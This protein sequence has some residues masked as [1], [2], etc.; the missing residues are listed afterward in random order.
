VPEAGVDHAAA[1]R[2]AIVFAAAAGAG[3]IA[4]VSPSIAVAL[5]TGSALAVLFLAFVRRPTRIFLGVL[6]VLLTGYAFLGKGLAHVGFPPLYIG[7]LLLP[8]AVVALIASGR[9]IRVGFVEG[10]IL[11]FIA[12]GFVRMLPGFSIYGLDSLRDSVVWG[13]AVY[14][15]AVAW[16]VGA[17][18]FGTLTRWYARLIPVFLAWIPLA[19]V[20][21]YRFG[22]SL[23]HGPGSDLPILFFKSGDYAV[24]LGGIAAFMLVGLYA[25][26]RG[27]QVL[28]PIIWAGWLAGLAIVGALTR[29]GML[30]AAM[31]G[32]VILFARSAGR[33]I[34]AAAVALAVVSVLLLVNPEIDL[35]TA[36]KVSFQ[37]LV[38]NVLSVV[39]EDASSNLR[40]SRDWRLEWW[41]TIVAYTVEG[42]YFWTGKGFGVNLANDDGFQVLADESLRA[43]HNAHLAILARTG[44]P[45]LVIWVAL[46]VAIAG[47]LLRAGLRARRAGQARWVMIH[48]WLFAY[49]LA[50]LVNMTFDVYLEGPQGGIWFWVL[51]GLGLASVRAAASEREAGSDA[52][53]GA[54]AAPPPRRRRFPFFRPLPIATQVTLARPTP[55]RAAD[56]QAAATAPAHLLAA[57][58]STADMSGAFFEGLADRV[59]RDR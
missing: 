16:A 57:P 44:V 21:W 10:L 24:H 5:V 13:Y 59:E 51:V 6:A 22:E 36:R 7:E 14:A 50:A 19:A 49:W 28:E 1:F 37:Q 3:A 56:A 33:W 41:D 42:P 26:R 55:G 58:K 47:T 2:W 35:G 32:S 18:D 43:P 45:G 29:G 27:A 8:L 20:L 9:R 40:D 38:D 34:S 48:G 15:L 54:P 4:A 25:A 39:N 12:F 30:A 11:A 17:A 53:K 23:P 52:G 46:Q 31:S